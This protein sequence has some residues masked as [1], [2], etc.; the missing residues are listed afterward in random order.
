MPHDPLFHAR[1]ED[2]LR[3]AIDTIV[4]PLVSG[5]FWW[6]KAPEEQSYPFATAHFQDGGGKN[7][8]FFG[9]NGWE[10]LVSL[11]IRG[12]DKLACGSLLRTCVSAL[13][14]LQVVES[15]DPTI[16]YGTM[17]QPWRPIAM[18]PESFSGQI[19]YT[20]GIILLI[21]LYQA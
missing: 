6:Y 4:N 16:N 20:S 15:S 1:I 17:I 9:G 18:P 10:G 3:I 21:R 7:S 11:M 14:S 5:G 19:V 2:D 13:S 12:T 8:D